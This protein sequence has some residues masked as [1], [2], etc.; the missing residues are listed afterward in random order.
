MSFEPEDR[1]LTEAI[2]ARTSGPVCG[3]AHERLAA[4]VDRA[5]DPMEASLI[6]GHLERCPECAALARALVAMREDLPLLAEVDHDP[7]FTREVL[8]RTTSAPRRTPLAE[9]YVAV[10]RRL[11]ERP[12]VALEGAFV[13]AM[14]LALASGPPVHALNAIRPGLGKLVREACGTFSTSHASSEPSKEKPR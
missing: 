13:G 5:L 1:E 12:R 10:V 2:L 3:S 14:I 6:G 4:Y 11:L 9:R 7:A 8:A